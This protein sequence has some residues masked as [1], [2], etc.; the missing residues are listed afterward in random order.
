MQIWPRWRW[1]L[2]PEGKESTNPA[3]FLKS[4]LPSLLNIN[5]KHDQIKIER[6]HSILMH[7]PTPG[8]RPRTVILK[9]HN[10]Q[11]KVCILQVA[12]AAGKLLYKQCII[13]I[14]KDLSAVIIRKRK[15]VGF[16]MIYPA[17]LRVQYEGA[18]FFK[19]PTWNDVEDFLSSLPA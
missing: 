5:F 15:G 8:E 17:V 13:F 11:D 19:Q 4:W 7:Q 14:Y 2:G 12:Q 1:P 6:A 18:K 16:A 10:F 9:L 3:L